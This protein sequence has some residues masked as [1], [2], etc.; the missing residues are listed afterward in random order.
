M[1]FAVKRRIVWFS[2]SSS[3]LQGATLREFSK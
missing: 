2:V 1:P 3:I